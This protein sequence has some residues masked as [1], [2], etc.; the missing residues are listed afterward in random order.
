MTDPLPDPNAAPKRHG[1]FF[2]GCL[3]CLVLM[4]LAGVLVFLGMRWVR[5][6]IHAY[7]DSAPMPMPKVEMT[8]TELQSLEARLKAFGDALDQGKPVEPL[9]LTERELNAWITRK[10]EMKKLAD[11]VHVTLK[12]DQVAGQISLPLDGLGWFGRG[13]YLNGEASFNVSL[14]NGI[15][16]VT[17]QEVKVKGKPLPEEFMKEVRK[18]NLAKDA[19][20]N[21]DQAAVLSKL[22]SI[23]V[24]DGR[25]IIKERTPDR[26]PAE[27][28]QVPAPNSR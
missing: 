14:N 3:T 4:L 24:Q 5:N 23:E 8:D 21:P 25:V 19:Y 13:R 12:G 15:L 27:E 6:Q 1:C 26:Q 7:T 17:A 28:D 9:V 18:E 10:P 16:I 11:K 2:Y 20:N 22:E